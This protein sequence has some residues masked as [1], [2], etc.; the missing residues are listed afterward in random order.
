MIRTNHALGPT[1][2][3]SSPTSAYHDAR[4]DKAPHL[5]DH[6]FAALAPPPG[7][8]APSEGDVQKPQRLLPRR[9]AFSRHWE[10]LARG[11]LP[12]EQAYAALE[13]EL[14]DVKG[15]MAVM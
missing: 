15:S 8:P 6:A 5:L 9:G 3:S 2:T 4:K 13:M 11:P 1:V 10:L 14:K 7:A 12:M